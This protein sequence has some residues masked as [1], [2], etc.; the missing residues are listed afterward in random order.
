MIKIISISISN[1]QKRLKVKYGT[2]CKYDNPM[3]SKGYKYI[4]AY[5][6][7][8]SYIL[9]LAMQCHDSDLCLD[10]REYLNI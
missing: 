4:N 7:S 6:S 2:K 1:C 5:Y 3:S 9:A 10:S 8:M